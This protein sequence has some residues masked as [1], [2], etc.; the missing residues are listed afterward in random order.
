MMKV[1]EFNQVIE[2]Q[3]F[4]IGEVF[5]LGDWKFEVLGKR[6]NLPCRTVRRVVCRW[7]VTE[8]EFIYAIYGL[9]PE[10]DAVEF[11]EKHKDEI[12]EKYKK[13]IDFLFAESEAYYAVI[14]KDA[15]TS[16]MKKKI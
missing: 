13:G 8:D 4:E 1:S 11:Y 7:D 14:M 5:W 15:I 9:Y 2:E 10:I 16:A 3:S 12:I 6:D